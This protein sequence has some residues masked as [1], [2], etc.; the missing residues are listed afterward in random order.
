M[1]FAMDH[2]SWGFFQNI[3]FKAIGSHITNTAKTLFTGE[4]TTPPDCLGQSITLDGITYKA[5]RTKTKSGSNLD[6]VWPCLRVDNN[7]ILLDLIANGN[8]GWEARTAPDVGR[9]YLSAPSTGDTVA[10]GMLDLYHNLLAAGPSTSQLTP[11]TTLT[12]TF[13]STNPPTRAEVRANAG[14]MLVAAGMYAAV[15]VVDMTGLSTKDKIEHVPGVY[16][17]IRG[18]ANALNSESSNFVTSYASSLRAV[19]DCI[20]PALPGPAAFLLGIFTG[21]LSTISGML[22]GLWGELTGSNH[23]V[24]TVSQSGQRSSLPVSVAGTATDYLG[25][26]VGHTRRMTLNED[27]TGTVHIASGA[28]NGEEWTLKWASVPNGIAITIGT[29]VDTYGEGV[30][31][32]AEGKKW[33]ATLFS[34]DGPSGPKV[35]SVFRDGQMQ[36]NPEDGLHWCS[37]RYGHS[38]WCGA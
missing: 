31:G 2:L 10:V 26:W 13:D 22:T 35:L 1:S 25:Q 17:C 23:G 16:D 11:D 12:Y 24:I 21:G 8:R 9:G 3:D 4:E 29:K 18:A 28:M 36:R 34:P 5:D 6:A 27:G 14:L 30:G 32:F 19:I 33:M 37:E 7:K 15:S 20:T 38:L